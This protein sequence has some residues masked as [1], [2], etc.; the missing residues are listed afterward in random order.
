MAYDIEDISAPRVAGHKLKALVMAME[1]Q[2]TGPVLARQMLSNV[3]LPA[4]RK[5]EATDPLPMAHPSR[6][7]WFPGA[8]AGEAEGDLAAALDSDDAGKSEGSFVPETAAQFIDAYRS[9]RLTPEQVAQRVLEALAA[10]DR[11]AP[12]MRPI[13][14]QNGDDLREQAAASAERWA[15]GEPLGPLDGVPIAVKDE[16]DQQGYPTT[17]GTSFHGSR[18]ASADA[19]AVARLRAA[20]ALLVGKANMQ[21]IG[22]GVFGHNPHYSPARNPYDPSHLCGGSSSGSAGAVAAG[23][24]PIAVGVDGGGSIR[25]P[26]AFCGQL[27]L[28]ATFGRIS[29]HGAAPLAFSVS[30]VGPIAA[31]ARD[32]ALAY[33]VMAGPDPKDRNTLGQPAVSL[34]RA[35]DRSLEGVTLGVYRQWFEHGA[36]DVVDV[37]TDLLDGL[38]AA[39]ATIKEIEIPE[40]GALRTVHLVTIVSEMVASQLPYQERHRASYSH[41]TRVNLALGRRLKAGDY[42]HAQRLRVRFARQFAEVLADVDAIVTPATAVTA[43]RLR[44]D[45]LETGESDLL[46]TG[47]VM[48]F[49]P[50]ANLIGVPALSFPAGYDSRGL[51]VGMQAMGRWW[52][53]DVLLRLAAAAE[54]IV[55][56]R[57]PKVSWRLLEETV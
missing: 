30:H 22:L 41:E 43:P 19:E 54:G 9:G 37:C 49:A 14:A 45:A 1:G 39:G 23:L 18:S 44:E 40:L 11:L 52:R 46:T 51:P 15:T 8:E 31:T 6:F 33:A 5:L 21:E 32:L 47:R 53:E 3:G 27:G 13:I 7:D 4:F 25:I 55:E 34:D 38:V 57:Q 24:C 28:M 29:E 50:A 10:G 56:R 36:E 16:L 17:V 2:I 20:G 26:A 42:V 48:R 12:P 35:L